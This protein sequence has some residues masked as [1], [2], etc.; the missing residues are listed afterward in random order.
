MA[1]W[2]RRYRKPRKLFPPHPL[3]DSMRS[4]KVTQK[5]VSMVTGI[6]TYKLG[7]YLNGYEFM[8]SW[9]EEKIED[10]VDILSKD[11]PLWEKHE[12][13]KRLFPDLVG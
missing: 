11:T 10:A 7:Q 12:I 13:F 8:P 1:R 4:Q 9:I 5:Q 3:K 2:R 6:S